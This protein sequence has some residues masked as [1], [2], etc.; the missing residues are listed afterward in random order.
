MASPARHR[1]R[2]IRCGPVVG[3]VTG[4]HLRRKTQ[5][6]VE[7]ARTR[8]ERELEQRRADAAKVAENRLCGLSAGSSKASSSTSGR[9]TCPPKNTICGRTHTQWTSRFPCRSYKSARPWC[10]TH[11]VGGPAFRQGPRP[12]R[13]TDLNGTFQRSQ[14][15]AIP[16]LERHSVDGRGW[17]RTSDLSRVRRACVGVESPAN[18]TR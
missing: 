3:V 13:E 2:G 5:V 18:R 12:S 6:E 17:V 15:G 1:C 14:S 7:A 10:V 9:S 11:A 16:L 8:R 4:K